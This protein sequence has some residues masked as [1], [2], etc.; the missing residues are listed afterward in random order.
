MKRLD[1]YWYSQNPVAWLLLPLAGLFCLISGIR[2]LFFKTGIL[3][4]YKMPVPVII[5][6]NINVGG[7]GKTPLLVELC[8]QLRAKGLKPGII[9][10]GYGGA[11]GSWPCEVSDDC[12][13]IEVGDEPLLIALRTKCPVVVGPDRI[14]DAKLLLD[15][16]E[17]NVILSDDGLQHYR[18]KRDVEIVVVDAQR[19]LGNGFCLPAGPL[20]ETISRLATVDMVVLNG[21]PV[22]QLSYQ[23]L[24]TN[25]LPLGEAGQE[26]PLSEF[27][28]K[29]VH[30]IAGI[31]H[32]QRF[33]NMLE[34]AGIECVRHEF[35]DHHVFSQADI[36]FN[37]DVPV[38]MTEKDAVKCKAFQLSR[39]WY[40][41]IDV[42]LSGTAQKRFDEIVEQVCYG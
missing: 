6:G 9:S 7:T 30:A 35:S 40:V 28:G 17:C 31:G 15:K 13:A 36:S 32:P 42:K 16:H 8:Q 37:D 27:A 23:V 22:D 19:N 20:R 39:H 3:K 4:S 38:L 33:F 24:A 26:L 1:H 14:A 29:K 18:L 34:D 21:G 11:S 2:K 25:C 12:D 41:P 5:V 10:R